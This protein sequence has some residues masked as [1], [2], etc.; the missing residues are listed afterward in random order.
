MSFG[1]W[2]KSNWLILV[3]SG[4]SVAALPTAFYFSSKMHKDLIKIQQT[5]ANADW[6]GVSGYE[7]TYTIPAVRPGQEQFSEKAPLN[8][9]LIDLIQIKRNE[10][11]VES[12]KVGA[13][14]AKFNEGQ[15]GERRHKPAIE[16]VL[17]K[18]VGS[19]RVL[20]LDM[21]RWF[22]QTAYPALLTRVNAG[23]PPDVNRVVKELTES[24][25]IVKNR[26]LSTTGAPALSPEQQTELTKQLLTERVNAYRRQAAKLSFYAEPRNII[27]MPMAPLAQQSLP[28]L[29][30]FWDWQ[31]K[32]WIYDDV[33]SAIALANT[34]RIPGGPEGVAGSVV[35]RVL[36]VGVDPLTTMSDVPDDVPPVD[37]NVMTPTSSEPIK[38]NEAL[39]VTGRVNAPDNQF[40][41]VRNLKIELVVAPERLPVFFDA[42]A[43]T[44]FM[45]V[46]LCELEEHPILEDIKEGY[47]Y[48][49]EHVV[50][51]TI[52]IETLWLRAWTTKYM[53]ESVK[54]ALSVLEVKPPE[55]E[56]VEPPK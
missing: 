8:Q 4:V 41:D 22:T 11:K 27:D 40:Y 35:K 16:G 14:A 45:T 54:R 51:A 6:T 50:K 28:T 39:S 7:V 42:L 46:L 12:A 37:E 15:G 53:P 13:A 34:S 33:L 55:V 2:A 29:A 30:T 5:K 52:T 1:T 20:Q 17:P 9:K 56:A 32:Y 3:L 25:G 38:L 36:K 44:N 21:L 23:A 31:V 24:Q 10:V 18:Y 43:K 26:M 19:V 47:F 48:G 49:D